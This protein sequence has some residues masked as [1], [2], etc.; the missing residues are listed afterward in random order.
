MKR[1]EPY[2]WSVVSGHSSVSAVVAASGTC[3]VTSV[4]AIRLQVASVTQV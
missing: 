3:I 2:Q 4:S 1:Q